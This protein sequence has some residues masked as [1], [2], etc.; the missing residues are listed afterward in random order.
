MT[1]SSRMYTCSHLHL[2]FRLRPVLTDCQ[3]WRSHP[4]SKGGK[5]GLRPEIRGR[6][7]SNA[8]VAGLDRSLYLY[9]CRTPSR[10]HPLSISIPQKKD[11]RKTSRRPSDKGILRYLFSFI[12]LIV[13]GKPCPR[14][15]QFSASSRSAGDAF[16][17]FHLPCSQCWGALKQLG[18]THPI[19]SCVSNPAGTGVPT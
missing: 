17:L 4:N 10:R 6:R 5:D 9:L 3:L 16:G 18:N 7:L 2:H 15:D 14:G 8:S 12:Q 19:S 13:F 11:Q 1:S